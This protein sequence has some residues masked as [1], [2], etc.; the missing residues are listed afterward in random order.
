MPPSARSSPDGCREVVAEELG[1]VGHR[2]GL[3]VGDASGGAGWYGGVE[4]VVDGSA[5]SGWS[6][7]VGQSYAGF[8]QQAPTVGRAGPSAL[9][10]GPVVVRRRG[11]RS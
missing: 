4:D 7:V 8:C 5:G 11:R 9:G 2:Y 6:E 3:A 1:W 10:V